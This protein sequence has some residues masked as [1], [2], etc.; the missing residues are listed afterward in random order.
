MY[1]YGVQRM[2][3]KLWPK[4]FSALVAL[5]VIASVAIVLMALT[6]PQPRPFPAALTEVLLT[7]PLAIWLGQ[8]TAESL[9]VKH[10]RSSFG[11]VVAAGREPATYWAC[12]GVTVTLSAAFLVGFSRALVSL[13]AEF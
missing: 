2:K 3:Q 10:W 1:K 12:T 13:V 6:H 7:A 5:V 11:G 4:E 9:Q 8:M